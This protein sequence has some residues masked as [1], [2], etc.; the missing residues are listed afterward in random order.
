MVEYVLEEKSQTRMVSA[1]QIDTERSCRRIF[2][3]LIHHRHNLVCSNSKGLTSLGM[4]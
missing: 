1:V 3:S 2:F 4:Q